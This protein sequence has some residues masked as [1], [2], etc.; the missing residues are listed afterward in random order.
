VGCE[1]KI[2][3]TIIKAIAVPMVNQKRGRS[4][5]NFPVQRKDSG[6]VVGGTNQ[7]NG[8]EARAILLEAPMEIIEPVE[9]VRVNNGESALA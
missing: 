9:V 5:H 4:F 3:A 8:I 2:V 1:A 6:P 7:P